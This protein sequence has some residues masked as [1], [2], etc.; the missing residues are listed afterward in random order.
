MKC[1]DCSYGPGR[2]WANGNADK[3]HTE[4]DSPRPV[5][6]PIKEFPLVVCLLGPCRT[7]QDC[8][9]IVLCVWEAVRLESKK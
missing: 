5:G 8:I 1:Y 7:S 9:L 2:L 3:E 6:D 4:A